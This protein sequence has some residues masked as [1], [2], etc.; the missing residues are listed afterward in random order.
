[1]PTA[2]AWTHQNME[3]HMRKAWNQRLPSTSA[4]EE[5]IPAP[6]DSCSH[7][8][9]RLPGALALPNC[10]PTKFWPPSRWFAL[11]W[12]LW[13]TSSLGFP[14]IWHQGYCSRTE[15]KALSHKEICS[16]DL[17]GELRSPS[18]SFYHCCCVG[19]HHELQSSNWQNVLTSV[20]H[21]T[22]VGAPR[23]TTDM[24][25]GVFAWFSLL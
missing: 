8:R 19:K 13:G 7:T 9:A 4:A 25:P 10:P 18:S 12:P 5:F 6:S 17:H 22:K 23:P 15:H 1:M 3:T 21:Y 20:F 14:G 24:A 2:L 16:Q 11:F